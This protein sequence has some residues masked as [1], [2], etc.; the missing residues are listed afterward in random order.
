MPGTTITRRNLRRSLYDQIPY[1]GF[2]GTSDSMGAGTVVD[3]YAFQDSNLSTDTYRGA[4]IYRPDQ[5]N[6]DM[7][8]K[9]GALTLAT[10]T[11]AHTGS[12]YADTGSAKIYEIVGHMHPDELNA[13]IHRALKKVYFETQTVLSV[14]SNGTSEGSTAG[15]ADMSVSGVGSWTTVGTLSTKE[16]STSGY[17]VYSG[18]ASL[19]LVTSAS[20][21][22]VS[23]IPIRLNTN[24][25]APE[26]VFVSVILRAES[27]TWTVELYDST[28]SAAIKS[29]TT[30]HEGWV[31]VWIEEQVPATCEEVKVRVYSALTTEEAYI[32]NVV[33]Y[34]KSDR[35]LVAPTWLN[36]PH[37]FLKLREARYI[38]NLADHVDDANSRVF[39]DWSQP[40]MFSL[41]PLHLDSNPYAVQL[42]KPLPQAD[43]WIHGKRPYY[44]VET[45]AADTDTTTAPQDLLESYC[46][47]EIA[48]YLIK[49]YPGDARWTTLRAEAV[50]R[51]K[52]E[53]M[54]R[55]EMPMQPK[56]RDIPGRI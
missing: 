7:V 16:K 8:K 30:T 38:R 37:K 1:L 41:D 28:N 42:N 14:L 15:D 3:T 35:R 52:A 19:H 36:E 10:G 26:R 20:S 47:L 51:V 45:L 18:T 34:R 33:V 54:A 46:K 43:L 22:G 40:A 13:C 21:S 24:S 17:L 27:G 29:Y 48:D 44:D 49:R 55:P 11:L 56:R 2:Y 12:N 6:D 31:R 53:T 50:S 32:D 5:T 39:Q 23:S 25:G 9:A 4:Y